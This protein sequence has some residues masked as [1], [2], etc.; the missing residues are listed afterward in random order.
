MHDVKP[1]F[2]KKQ[3]IANKQC[4]IDTPNKDQN[5]MN[6]WTN[7]WTDI[8]M[9]GQY[10]NSIPPPNPQT[11]FAGCWRGRGGGWIIRNIFQILSTK[12]FHQTCCESLVC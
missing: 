9:D 11:Q 4:L 2:L 6:R 10:Q 3:E 12:T 5:I 7:V 8:W 1:Y